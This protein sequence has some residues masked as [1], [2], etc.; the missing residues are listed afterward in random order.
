MKSTNDELPVMH[1]TSGPDWEEWLKSNHAESE[2]IWMKLAKK[3]SPIGSVSYADAVDIALCYGWI[4]SQK[5]ALDAHFS[6]QR[7]TR[8]GARSKWSK[9]NCGKV[10]NLIAQ[11]RMRPP[12][13]KEIE[14]ARNDGR[15]DAAYEPPSTIT[16]PEDLQAELEKYPEAGEFF[17]KLSG[18]NR[19]S[20]LYQ[21]HDAK[22]PET[23]ARRIEKYVTMLREGKKPHG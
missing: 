17:A 10:E 8:R 1:F 3:N 18:S 7:F 4:D 11:G 15:W 5:M 23:R 13:L 19:Y 20:I 9:I 22:K 14:A 6:L 12:G 2:G 16:V 21:I